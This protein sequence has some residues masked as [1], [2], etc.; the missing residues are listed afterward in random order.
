LKLSS[1]IW[2]PESSPPFAPPVPRAFRRTYTTPPGKSATSASI[3]IT[4]DNEYTL[5]IN[6]H[7][8]GSTQGADARFGWQSPHRYGVAPLAPDT[9]VFAVTGVN[10]LDTVSGG[11]SAAGLL[12]A[13]QVTHE[14]GS[15]VVIRS[16]GTWRASKVIPGDFEAPAFDDSAWP[17]AGMLGGYGAEP[18]DVE[19]VF[20]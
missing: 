11:Y 14:D 15:T 17:P 13:I 16:D 12:V 18:W 5:Y 1:W 10:V 6:G 2:T 20:P 9:N 19:L 7:L 4:A 3:L 8:A